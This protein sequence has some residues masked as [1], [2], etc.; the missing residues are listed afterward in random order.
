MRRNARR[1]LRAVNRMQSRIVLARVRMVL[2]VLLLVGQLDGCGRTS[3]AAP[4]DSA[5]PVSSKIAASL[6]DVMQRLHDDG[7][8]AS[9]VTLRQPASYSTA[10]VRVDTA[11]R[12]QVVLRVTSTNAA[13]VAQLMQHHMQIEQVDTARLLIQGWVFFERLVTLSGLPF[14]QYIR[15]PSYAVRRSSAS[16]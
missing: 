5:A 16:Y 1:S 11:G 4:T 14:V 12:L 2:I 6:R 9:N 15:P 13:V 3:P 10:L 8:T 7:V